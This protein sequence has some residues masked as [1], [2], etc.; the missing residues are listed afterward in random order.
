V[1]DTGVG[2]SADNLAKLFNNFT[3][4]EPQIGHK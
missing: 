1:R 3:Q 4:A 2:I